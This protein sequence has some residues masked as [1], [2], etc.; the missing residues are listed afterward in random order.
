MLALNSHRIN[1]ADRR[2]EIPRLEDISPEYRD[3]RR[4]RADLL[5]RLASINVEIQAVAAS[6]SGRGT[7]SERTEADGVSATVATL[8]GD[9]IDEAP[10]LPLDQSARAED[11]NAAITILDRRLAEARM[12]ASAV[13]RE[14]VAPLHAE[15]VKVI[16]RAMVAVYEA[17]VAYDDLTDQLNAGEV[18]WSALHPMAPRDVVEQDNRYSPVAIYLRQAA[19]YGFIPPSEIPAGIR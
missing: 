7:A 6:Y 2:S 19:G 15:L 3:L 5:E 13:V 12:K 8:V 4:R 17:A 10:A 14:Q 11:L 16:C 9:P 18:A 1:R